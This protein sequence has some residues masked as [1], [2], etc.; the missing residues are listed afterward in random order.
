MGYG[1]DGLGAIPSRG[2]I[3]LYPTTFRRTRPDPEATQPPFLWAISPSVKR[4]RREADH[5]PPS[6]A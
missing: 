3:L 4:Q 5:S 1:L 2:K 6:N